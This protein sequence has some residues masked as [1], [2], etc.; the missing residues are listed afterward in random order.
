MFFGLRAWKSDIQFF[1]PPGVG[2]AAPGVGPAAPGVG[3]AAPGVGLAVPG[4]GLA[5]TGQE[6]CRDS[7]VR[8]PPGARGSGPS[9]AK[10]FAVI[11]GVRPPPG[12]SLFFGFSTFT[13][14]KVPFLG[15]KNDQKHRFSNPGP[16]VHRNLSGKIS[17]LIR[18]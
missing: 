10:K 15:S 17:T 8:P 1:W 3:L 6:V 2:L 18:R 4:V 14:E 13:D 7:G 5:A 16:N 12:A 9:L 11:T